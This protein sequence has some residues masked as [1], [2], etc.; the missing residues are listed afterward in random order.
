VCTGACTYKRL[1]SRLFSAWYCCLRASSPAGPAQPRGNR[2]WAACQYAT[3][4]P[5]LPLSACPSLP[6]L[7][8]GAQAPAVRMLAGAGASARGRARVCA[9]A[10]A[11]ARA[12]PGWR[13]PHVRVFIS[14]SAC[15]PKRVRSTHG[16]LPAGPITQSRIL[17]NALC[18]ACCH[19]CKRASVRPNAGT[20][21]QIRH[22]TH[23]PATAAA[24]A[25]RRA[26]RQRW[27]QQQQQQQQAAAGEGVRDGDGER[28]ARWG[29]EE[30]TNAGD[31]PGVHAPSAPTTPPGTSACRLNAQALGGQRAWG[32]RC[33][34]DWAAQT[35]RF[36]APPRAHQATPR[37]RTPRMGAQGASV[38]PSVAQQGGR[39]GLRR[40]T[41]SPGRPC[42]HIT[43]HAQAGRPPCHHRPRSTL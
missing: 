16:W 6:L 21:K 43:P 20:S 13:G 29:E 7:T 31:R 35:P 17:P 30:L 42:H 39:W 37:P 22:S 11:K 38:H 8:A 25:S 28:G 2:G 33:G 26:Q 10:T 32:G 5:A 36:W 27:Q 15:R 1:L 12:L 14:S 24:P 41:P 4:C 19:A 3:R 23:Q 34:R 40:V 9:W 18:H